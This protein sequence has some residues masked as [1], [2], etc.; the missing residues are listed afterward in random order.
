MLSVLYYILV[1][2]VNQIPR[3]FIGSFFSSVQ[4]LLYWFF[5]MWSYLPY[6]KYDFTWKYSEEVYCQ[7]KNTSVSSSILEMKR[8]GRQNFCLYCYLDY[9]R[10]Q[11]DFHSTSQKMPIK[12]SGYA[13]KIRV[14]RVSRNHRYFFGQITDIFKF[15]QI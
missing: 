8:V 10:Q 1:S 15:N 4:M 14:G 12:T 11:S 9:T 7:R 2:N 6:F 13:L 3:L 5:F